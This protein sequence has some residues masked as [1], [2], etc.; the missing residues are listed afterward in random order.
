MQKKKILILDEPFAG[1]DNINS[2]K[3]FHMLSKRKETIIM[4]S[5]ETDFE[6]WDMKNW[7]KVRIED[8]CYEKI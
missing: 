5:H 2:K 8:I 1:V 6:E 4:V 7:E 3:I